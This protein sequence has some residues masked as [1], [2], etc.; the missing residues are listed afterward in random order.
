MHMLN[1]CQS[2]IDITSAYWHQIISKYITTHVI[3]IASVSMSK[4][5]KPLSKLKLIVKYQVFDIKLISMIGTLNM[6]TLCAPRNIH[7]I[8]NCNRWF[9]SWRHWTTIKC[10]YWNTVKYT[11]YAN[12]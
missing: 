5:N 10:Y 11:S 2:D 1:R 7:L 6:V 8:E 12:K 3:I 9:N 4:E